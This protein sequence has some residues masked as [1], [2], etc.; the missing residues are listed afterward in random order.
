[1]R[2]RGW[3]GV[4]WLRGA[5]CSRSHGILRA[6]GGGSHLW[7]LQADSSLGGSRCNPCDIRR[8]HAG[9]CFRRHFY[10]RHHLRR[11]AVSH[12]A[13]ANTWPLHAARPH[14]LCHLLPRRAPHWLQTLLQHIQRANNR[15]QVKA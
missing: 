7:L 6:A 1:M 13:A 12:A 4:G 5:L 15:K 9:W 2:V 14:H 10:R 3:V 8:S 11:P